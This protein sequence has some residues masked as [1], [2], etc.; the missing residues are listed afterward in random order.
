MEIICSDFARIWKGRD[1]EKN[2]GFLLLLFRDVNFGFPDPA[3]ESAADISHENNPPAA[4]MEP[5][6]SRSF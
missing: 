3:W 6:L 1:R 5:V 4:G 2:R